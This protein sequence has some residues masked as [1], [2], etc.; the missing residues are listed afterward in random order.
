VLREE[1]VIGAW[2]IILARDRGWLQST[3]DVIGAKKPMTSFGSRHPFI[4]I[5]ST[6]PLRRRGALPV[7]PAQILFSSSAGAP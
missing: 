7:L 5:V 2:N 1:W 3:R 6:T 4:Q